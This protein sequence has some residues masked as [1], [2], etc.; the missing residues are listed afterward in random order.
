[1]MISFRSLSFLILCSVTTFVILAGCA[2]PKPIHPDQLQ[3][4][5]LD[6]QLPE[7][8]TIVLAN[9]IR[10]YLKE[11][12]ELPLVQMTAMLGSG[13]MTT[14]AD[15]SGFASL[16]GSTWRTGGAGERSPEELDEYLDHLAADLSASLGAYT[17][18][19]NLSLRAED[20]EYGV[21]V[22]GDLLRR[23][24]FAQERLELARLQAQE[25]LR[26]QNDRPGS[27]SRRLLMA[28][29]CIVLLPQKFSE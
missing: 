6:F 15:K 11:D 27:I 14:P 29:M 12:K 13:A 25:Q 2:V 18:Q 7:V 3:Y 1:M 20:L 19:L 22:L 9:G 4:P 24:T 28:L 23:P 26:R 5:V 16:F 10:L 17:A 8:E 21:A